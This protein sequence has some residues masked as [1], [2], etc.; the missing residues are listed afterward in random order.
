MI[1]HDFKIKT[2]LVFREGEFTHDGQTV[3]TEFSMDGHELKGIKRFE[4]KADAQD[5]TSIIIEFLPESIEF[6]GQADVI[7]SLLVAEPEFEHGG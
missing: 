7:A 1:R 4:I 2:G 3:K 6:E 5:V